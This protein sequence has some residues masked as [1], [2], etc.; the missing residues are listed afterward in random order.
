MESLVVYDTTFDDTRTIAA[1]VAAG[2]RGFGQ[3]RLVGLDQLASHD[4]R[5]VDLLFVGGPTK[6]HAGNLRMRRFASAL[7]TKSPTG[8]VAASFDTRVRTHA[9]ISNSAAK[10]IGGLLRRAGIRMCAPAESFFVSRDIPE[11]ERGEIERAAAW[12]KMIADRLVLSH[13]CA[14]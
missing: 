8:M 3:V 7:K 4:L 14:A 11:L 12:A 10:A 1:A 5:V 2:L 6:A 9:V 13:W